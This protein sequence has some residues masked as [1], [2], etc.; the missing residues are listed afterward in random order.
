MTIN[1]CFLLKGLEVDILKIDTSNGLAICNLR[2]RRF[3]R[4]LY[5][6]QGNLT[7][8]PPITT[9]P[10]NFWVNVIIFFKI[11]THIN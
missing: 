3:N 1:L 11:Y 10:E 7:F 2:V 8:K 6:V 4:T 9:K 5:V